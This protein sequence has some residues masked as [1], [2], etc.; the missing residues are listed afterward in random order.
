[1]RWHVLLEDEDETCLTFRIFQTIEFSI[2]LD[3]FQVCQ[4]ILCNN[5]NRIL[6]VKF[7]F[8][9]LIVVR[10]FSSSEKVLVQSRLFISVGSRNI[11][12]HWQFLLCI[13]CR[14]FAL[15]IFRGLFF[16]VPVFVHCLSV[17]S[18]SSSTLLSSILPSH[19]LFYIAE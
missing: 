12:M 10:Y 15:F 3:A 17:S 7:L 18:S 2:Y 5:C 4:D 6:L 16:L 8:L 13:L 14:Y 1:M 19:Y 11:S 9:H